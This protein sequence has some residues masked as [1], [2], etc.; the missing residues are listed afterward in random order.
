MNF[1]KINNSYFIRLERGEKIIESVKSFCAGNK[2]NCGYFF[3]IGA[4]GEAELA[5]Y[6]VESKKYTSKILKQPLEIISLSGNITEMEDEVYL[7]CHI[8]LSDEEMNAIGGH[9]KEGVISA[10]CEI[11][12]TK[13]DAEV[14]RKY[15]DFIGLNILEF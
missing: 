2:I 10:T 15:D 5:H 8:T 6:I 1:K 7:H 4:L 12:L 13:L 14:S 11:F 9:L 3:G